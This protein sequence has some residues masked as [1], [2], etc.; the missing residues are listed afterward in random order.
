MICRD[1]LEQIVNPH[2]VLRGDRHQPL[3]SEFVE[4]VH[5]LLGILPIDFV[6]EQDHASRVRAEVVR[7]VAVLGE[8]AGR[9]VDDEEDQIGA[10]QRPPRLRADLAGVRRHRRVAIFEAAGVGQLEAAPVIEGDDV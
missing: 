10:F 6:D 9:A 3:E 7:D 2:A 8:H 1:E 4:L 5:A